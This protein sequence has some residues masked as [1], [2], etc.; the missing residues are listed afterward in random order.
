[1]ESLLYANFFLWEHVSG[2]EDIAAEKYHVPTH[3]QEHI[4]YVTPGTRLRTGSAKTHPSIP[5]K[6]RAA[7]L[8]G[9]PDVS[10]LSGFPNPNS[11]TCSIYVTADCTRGKIHGLLT[12]IY[13]AKD[14]FVMRMARSH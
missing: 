5:S 12:A 4:D 7:S 13:S 10:L 6:K 14:C 2:S 9:R 3:I 11:T 8:S 1:M